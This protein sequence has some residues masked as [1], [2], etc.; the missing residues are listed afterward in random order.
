MAVDREVPHPL[1]DRELGGGVL[2]HPLLVDRQG[3]QGGAVL[4]GEAGDRVELALAV[5][6]VDRV[7]DRPAADQLERGLEH[8]DL[9]GVDHDRDRHRLDQAG[10]HLGHVADLVAADVGDADVEDVRPLGDLPLR[11]LDDPVPVLLEQELAEQHRAVGVGPL[12]DEERACVLAYRAG[13]V[14]AGEV[15][16]V[17]L[18]ARRGDRQPCGRGRDLDGVLGGGPAAAA[19]ERGPELA[20]EAAMV[21]GELARGEVIDGLAVDV[22][23]QAGVR[24][25]RDQAGRGLAEEAD[26]LDHQVGPGR[27]IQADNVHREGLDR[28]DRA[29]EIG[30]DQ[31]RPSGLHRQ[32]DEHRQL[33]VALGEGAGGR[34]HGALDLEDVLGGLDQ[35]PVG[36]AV[37]QAADLLLV[38]GEELVKADV[39]ER[40]Q[41]GRRPAG[42]EDEARAL[43]RAELVGHLAG[44]RGGLAV[45]FVGLVA[46]V[47][48]VED[49]AGRA[50]GVGLD[51]VRTGRVVGPVDLLDHVGAGLDEDLV[52]ALLAGEV[53]HRQ[54]VSLEH[55][56]H[57]A[58]AYEHA[59]AH[60]LEERE[61]LAA[62]DEV[63]AGDRQGWHRTPRLV[64]GRA[65]KRNSG[66]RQA[67]GL[68]VLGV[69]EGQSRPRAE[70]QWRVL[71]VVSWRR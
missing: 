13:G 17:G 37:D 62:A 8:V 71:R 29:A 52:A 40:D 69:G 24:L 55:R 28:R 41:A 14:E 35:D 21:V 22:L 50:E 38:V 3:D 60:R 18:R 32:L 47:V 45:E 36:A 9:G 44:D 11:E 6:E 61:A 2:G 59:L 4:P 34:D 67:S 54:V 53:L 20:G 39:A 5:L 27:T 7:D 31:H 49:E 46:D 48:L 70:P 68:G 23:R 10:E 19:D 16:R 66:G 64:A 25:D 43:R 51:A 30:A 33:L 42:A 15:G 65:G 1:G 58:V 56:P 26:V 63:E 12:A 57:R